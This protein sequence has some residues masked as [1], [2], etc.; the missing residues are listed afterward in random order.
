MTYP[1]L[2]GKD[3]EDTEKGF[4]NGRHAV[5][6]WTIEARTQAFS[7]KLWIKYLLIR[8]Y[9]RI[10]LATKHDITRPKAVTIPNLQELTTPTCLK[11]RSTLNFQIA[12]KLLGAFRVPSKRRVSLI[13]CQKQKPSE[14]ANQCRKCGTC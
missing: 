12:D 1:Q 3:L 13:R 11:T 2:S 7:R 8:S 9:K 6:F 4:R 5:F 14:E 10:F